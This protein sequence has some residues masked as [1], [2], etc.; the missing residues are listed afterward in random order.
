[1][2]AKER[3]QWLVPLAGGETAVVRIADDRSLELGIAER[4]GG[5][6]LRLAPLEGAQLGQALQDGSRVA[7]QPAPKRKR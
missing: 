5:P 3:P 7:A 2:N 4:P 1:M 6:I